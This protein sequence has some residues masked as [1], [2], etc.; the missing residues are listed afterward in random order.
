MISLSLALCSP[1]LA[2]ALG[3]NQLY[4]GDPSTVAPG[5]T[6]FQLYTDTSR[7]AQTRVGGVAFRH[8]LTRNTELKLAYS[9]LWNAAGPNVQLGPNIGLKW[10]FIGDG[11]KKPSMAISGLYVI[12]HDIA[13][14]SRKNDTGATLIGS[15]PTRYAELLGN[16]GHVWVGEKAPDLR[17]L[18]LAAVR[19]VAKTTVVALEYSSVARIGAGGPRPLGR[20]WAAGLVYGSG[21]GWSYGLQVGYLLDNPRSKWH[22]TLGVATYF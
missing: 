17:Y 1:R 3:N 22:T 11:R 16:Y 6:Q 8:G 7:A 2:S 19:P 5:K 13:G 14:R 9:Y 10:R 20:Q 15:Y 18:S 12:N 21:S 4:T